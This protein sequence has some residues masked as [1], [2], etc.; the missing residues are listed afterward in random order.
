MGVP[1]ISISLALE[2]RMAD[3]Q[4]ASLRRYTAADQQGV[5]GYPTDTSLNWIESLNDASIKWNG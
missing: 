2:S 1:T 5:G 4:R 3:L